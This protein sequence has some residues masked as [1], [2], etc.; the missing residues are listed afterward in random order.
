MRWIVPFCALL[1]ALA[2]KPSVTHAGE[3]DGWCAQATK[4]SSIVICA[5]AELRQQAL[6]RNKLFE[7]ARLK[8]SPEAFKALNDDQSR[9]IKSYTAQ[10]GVSIDGPAPSLPISQNV[11]NCYKRHSRARTA[12]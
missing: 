4:A 6:A 1:A 10:C 9:W 5:D 8:L 7:A 2:C 11:I 12:Y 3:M